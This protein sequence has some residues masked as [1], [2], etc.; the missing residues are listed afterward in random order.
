MAFL[1]APTIRYRVESDDALTVTNR[2]GVA[3]AFLTTLQNT[4]RN[5][6]A[7]IHLPRRMIDQTL[8]EALAWVGAE[9]LAQGNAAR[10]RAASRGAST[11]ARG[12][13]TS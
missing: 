13:P 12:S 1:D 2:I 6:R 5:D 10:A 7:R 8:A 4:L 11:T 9:N 3:E